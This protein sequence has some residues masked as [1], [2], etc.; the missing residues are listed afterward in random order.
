MD[1]LKSESIKEFCVGDI[2]QLVVFQ[3]FD[4]CWSNLIKPDCFEIFH[5]LNSHQTLS[6]H[7]KFKNPAQIRKL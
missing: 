3:K 1:K 2:V 5:R 4:Y 6:Y 7:V